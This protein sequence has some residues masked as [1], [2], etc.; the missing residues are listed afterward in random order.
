[1]YN[2]NE[3]EAVAASL[4][5]PLKQLYIVEQSKRSAHS[6][7]YLYGMFSSKKI[8]LFDTLLKGSSEATNLNENT[9]RILIVLQMSSRYMRILLYSNI[10]PESLT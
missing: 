4:E 2:R 9:V 6:N 7:A 8:V 1:M 10:R 3:I 5:Y